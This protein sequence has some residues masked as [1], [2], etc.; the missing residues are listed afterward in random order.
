MNELLQYYAMERFLYRLSRSQH[1]E[2]FILKGALLLPLW[3]GPATRATKDID[4]LGRTTKDIDG[5]VAI[6]N[7][8]L[9]VDVEVVDDGV[10]F[11]VRTVRGEEIR[12]V[13][14]YG[15]IRV[16]FTDT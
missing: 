14:E 4:L 5:L 9:Q 12:I 8:G 2:S 7:D 15:G 10:R 16:P 1:G 11:D 3:D 6:M 13:A